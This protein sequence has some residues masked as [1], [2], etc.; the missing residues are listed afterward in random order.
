M[1][2]QTELSPSAVLTSR[3][4]RSVTGVVLA[5]RRTAAGW[6]CAVSRRTWIA[7]PAVA[8]TDY[9]WLAGRRVRLWLT[10][11]SPPR[12]IALEC[13][14]W[15]EWPSLDRRYGR[16][17]PPDQAFWW[18]AGF[19]IWQVL[20]AARAGRLI[21]LCCAHLSR[22]VSRCLA[23][24]FAW[25]RESTAPALMHAHLGLLDAIAARLRPRRRWPEAWRAARRLLAWR[26][27]LLETLAQEGLHPVESA[28]LAPRAQAWLAEPDPGAPL[29]ADEW[30]QLGV[31]LDA[32]GRLWPEALERRRALVW[33]KVAA[34]QR[35]LPD[36]APSAEDPILS[37]VWQWTY[38][39][40]IGHAGS[41]KTTVVQRI[42]A[43][44]R[45][46]GLRVAIAAL[47]G[48]AAAR[49]GLQGVTLHR[50]LG[51]GPW[52]WGIKRL[53]ADVVIVDE[54]S[55]LTWDAAAALLEAAPGRVVLVGDPAQLPPVSGE[56]T[57]AELLARLPVV[58]LRHQHRRQAHRLHS[59]AC[60]STAEL[61]RITIDTIRSWATQGESWQVVTPYRQGPTGSVRLNQIV[62]EIVN[63]RGALIPGTLFR[64]GDRVGLIRA[65]PTCGAPNGL[66]GRL[67]RSTPEGV[68]LEVRRIEIGPIP[69]DA[70]ELAYAVTVHRAQGSEWERVLLLCPLTQ[71]RHGFLSP[72]LRYVGLTRSRRETLCLL[73]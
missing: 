50:L 21:R 15:P 2:Q 39:A 9:A 41:G 8:Q 3:A 23:N 57:F 36:L 47:T 7:L 55:M 1:T 59:I 65:V 37:T 34:N 62:Q 66:I 70:C 11:Q 53:P 31:R 61:I 29:T 18:R 46:R 51:Y 16:W 4:G 48:R 72:T 42:A 73:S 56:R 71:D 13:V 67:V 26:A 33:A 49:L 14:P 69:I 54:A 25:A 63:P 40:V 22:H 68:T 45:E 5:V 28:R 52:G 32:T 24:P 19:P 64:L 27:A 43:A 30:R 60:E 44:A 17:A 12:A 20:A 10:D 38:S 58:Q 6:Q 35:T